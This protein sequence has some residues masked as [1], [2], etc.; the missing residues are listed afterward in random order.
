[1]PGIARSTSA[2][3]EGYRELRQA[4]LPGLGGGLR[5]AGA[6]GLKADLQI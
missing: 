6:G 4:G 3:F 1:M 2:L 5:A